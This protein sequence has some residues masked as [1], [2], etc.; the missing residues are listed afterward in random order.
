M[1]KKFKFLYGDTGY[2]HIPIDIAGWIWDYEMP[3]Y[4]TMFTPSN[5]YELVNGEFNGIVDFLNL[6][7]PHSIVVVNQIVH[8]ET[9]SIHNVSMRGL[10]WGFNIQTERIE[11]TYYRFIPNSNENI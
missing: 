5:R 2:V 7:P 11:I 3:N 1:L 8:L 9:M 6:F 4:E 10:G